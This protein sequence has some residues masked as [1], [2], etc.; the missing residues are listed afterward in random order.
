MDGRFVLRE[1]SCDWFDKLMEEFVWIDEL[2]KM[3]KMKSTRDCRPF[4]L[5]L[6][7]VN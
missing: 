1:R 2:M 5:K 4:I 3:E 6:V 7:Q